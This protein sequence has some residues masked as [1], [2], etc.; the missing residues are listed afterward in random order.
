MTQN[1]KEYDA[2]RDVIQLE[3]TLK[4][5]KET[6]PRPGDLPALEE[7]LI[8]LNGIIERVKGGMK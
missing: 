2:W 6:N 7:C 8:L 3:T 5:L 1:T 4:L